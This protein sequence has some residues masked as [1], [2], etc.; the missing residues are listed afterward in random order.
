MGEILSKNVSITKNNLER[1]VREIYNST[2]SRP[3]AIRIFRILKICSIDEA[4]KAV[5]NILSRK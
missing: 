4:N 1:C 3:L 5:D 2:S